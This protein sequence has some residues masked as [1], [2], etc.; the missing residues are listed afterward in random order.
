MQPNEDIGESHPP[1]LSWV[2]DDS[3]AVSHVVLGQGR[4]GGSWHRMSPNVKSLSTG[5][6]L[7]LPIY[8]FETWERESGRGGSD[9]REERGGGGGG[10]GGREKE[11]VEGT[12][13]GGRGGGN[14][15]GDEAERRIRKGS[16]NSRVA[17]GSVAQ[18][19]NDYVTKMGLE[20]SFMNHVLVTQV[21]WSCSR[22][23]RS[24]SCDSTFSIESVATS[25]DS[26]S[27][28][29]P[30]NLVFETLPVKGSAGRTPNTTSCPDQ[31]TTKEE[32][33]A[34]GQ[35][36]SDIYDS[37]INSGSEAGDNGTGND[38]DDTGI[39]CCAKR[40]RLYSSN[41]RW[42]IRG[43]KIEGVKEDS[44]LVGVSAKNIVLATGV[45]DCPKRLNIPGEDCTFVHHGFAN[46]HDRLM[47]VKMHSDPILVVGAGLSAAD[48]ILHAL[49]S[50]L[51]VIH[52]FY[53]DPANPKLIYHTMDPKIY[54]DYVSLFSL[55]QGK[56]HHPKYT[57]LAQHR[58]VSFHL[59]GMCT[60]SDK[61]S[62]T[63][64]VTV[65]LV[66][67]MIGGEAQLKFLPDCVSQGLG[68]KPNCPIEV[69]KNPVDVDPYTFASDRYP[70]L[71]A[72]GP[73]TGDNFVRFVLGG[74][75]GIAQNIH[76]KLNKLH[77]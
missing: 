64:D 73:L 36:V 48:T 22:N 45:G 58:V 30:P 43:R 12:S 61:D 17:L 53:Q 49:D 44:E 37:N 20:D 16:A 59:G 74:G 56:A 46:L 27:P 69:K 25:D 3:R 68:V 32:V 9:G 71:Y 10:G 35:K 38:S 72:M 28:V 75:L 1:S 31:R 33:L 77:L 51:S 5:R 54:S 50:G 14:G 70:A 2:K 66:V 65:S 7:Q 42:I 18:Y 13:E 52:V 62:R 26:S 23:A 47:S 8:D 57:P 67:V 15:G 60:L 6:W 63:S 11:L 24:L 39:S 41:G 34:V 40:M 29:T 76:H 19:Y 21:A 55:M 4:A